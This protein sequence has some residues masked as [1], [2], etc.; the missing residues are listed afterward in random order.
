M[1]IIFA[2]DI[3]PEWRP[4][5]GYERYQISSTG[6]VKGVHGTILKTNPSK[7]RGGYCFVGL[8]R[9]AGDPI[10]CKNV[11]VLVALTFLPNLENK[12]QVNHINGN[13]AD[14]S[15]LNLEWATAQENALRKVH[16]NQTSRA[17]PIMESLADGT[18]VRQ[19]ISSAAVDLG[20]NSTTVRKWCHDRI[21][22][23]VLLYRFA[24]CIV[25][26]GEEWRD[27]EYNDVVYHVS[28]KGRVRTNQGSFT[29]GSNFNGYRRYSGK[30]I[31]VHRLIATAFLGP[32]AQKD[33][34]VNHKDGT[35]SNN[36]IENLEWSTQTENVIHAREIGANPGRSHPV[37]QIKP[38][39]E[40]V[41]FETFKAAGEAVG[42][43]GT[44]IA[45]ACDHPTRTAAGC[46]WVSIRRIILTNED[47]DAII[48]FAW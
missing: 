14:N 7:A 11:H 37:R 41:D 25:L 30:H 19:W 40:T 44:N 5:V 29:F 48:G 39:G 45:H 9:N 2:M 15:I 46:R 38:T 16:I 13:R 4:I 20:V 24:D 6:Q 22:I 43:A 42:L 10:E 27:V 28:S 34:V 23:G 3:L 32:P 12:L 21:L 18:M 35:K 8:R 47:V 26:P 1:P 17:R 31:L 36:T 33:F